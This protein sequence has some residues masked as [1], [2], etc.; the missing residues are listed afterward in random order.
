[1]AQIHAN[2]QVPRRAALTEGLASRLRPLPGA[3]LAPRKGRPQAALDQ[4]GQFRPVWLAI[5]RGLVIDHLIVKGDLE[6]AFGT[7]LQ[8]EAEKDRRPALQDLSCRT[9]SLVQVVSRDAVFDDDAVLR[10]D[11]RHLSTIRTSG[12]FQAGAPSRTFSPL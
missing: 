12:I 10:V 1:L 4:P 6:D 2:V 3:R 7:G 11:H 8:L 5:G 9:D